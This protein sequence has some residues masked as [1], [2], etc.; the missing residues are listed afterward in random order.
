[1]SHTMKLW[2]RVMEH[3]LRHDTSISPNQF[4]FMPGCSTIGAIFLIRSL[5]EK[6]RDV[7][8][9]LL[10]IFIDLERAYD[11]VPRDVL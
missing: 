9:N 7:K 5:M 4:G 3:R 11:S 1:M 6:Y 2:E 10:M 8:K